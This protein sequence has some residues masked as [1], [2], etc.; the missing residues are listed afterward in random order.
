MDKM[1][2]VVRKRKRKRKKKEGLLAKIAHRLTLGS[3][4]AVAV[5]GEAVGDGASK[6][7][8][9][10][11]KSRSKKRGKWRRDLAKNMSQATATW[12]KGS[13]DAPVKLIK[14]LFSKDKKK[15]RKSERR[16]STPVTTQPDRVPLP[17]AVPTP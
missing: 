16:A 12:L 17:T 1:P 4:K 13:A 15:R 9:K 14:T 5:L 7:R 2:M 6:Y 3:A 8:R 10:H 11:E